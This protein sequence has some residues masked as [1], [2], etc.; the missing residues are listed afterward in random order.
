VLKLNQV[1]IKQFALGN[2]SGR[3]NI[4]IP[5]F[6]KSNVEVGTRASLKY[7]DNEF[8][9]AHFKSESVYV[10]TIDQVVR[11]LKLNK[12]DFLKS[13]TE[14]NDLNVLDGGYDTIC[15]YKPIMMLEVSYNNYGLQKWFDFGYQAYH[16]TNGELLRLGNYEKQ[17][18]DLILIHEHK[19]YVSEL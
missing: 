19:P 15:K 12:L 18:S 9:N 5:V 6:N 4:L 14:G 10:K 13:D 8:T 2:S 7:N 3:E 16:Y 17:N 1:T 11:D